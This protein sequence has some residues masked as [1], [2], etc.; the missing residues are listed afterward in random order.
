MFKGK[1][2]PCAFG[3]YSCGDIYPETGGYEELNIVDRSSPDPRVGHIRLS[4]LK[5]LYV[6]AEQNQLADYLI[7]S[8]LSNEGSQPSSFL[9]SD[10]EAG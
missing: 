4:D 6:I 1:E 10:T 5:V 7:C 8:N 3:Q 9:L 2:R